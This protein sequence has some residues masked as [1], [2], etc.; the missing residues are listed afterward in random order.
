VSSPTKRWHWFEI[1]GFG[2]RLVILVQRD[3]IPVDLMVASERNEGIR[4]RNS[5]LS[6][7]EPA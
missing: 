4:Y 5:S 1:N 6:P 3:Q 7:E 2:S